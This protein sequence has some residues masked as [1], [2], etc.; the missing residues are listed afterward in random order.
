M[1]SSL[2]LANAA[3]RDN[4]GYGAPYRPVK[5]D[6]RGVFADID[7]RLNAVE[8]G[9]V[10]GAKIYRPENYGAVFDGSV[11]TASGVLGVTTL[12]GLAAYSVGGSTPYSWVNPASFAEATP[13]GQLFNLPLAAAA[14]DSDTTVAFGCNQ[15]VQT[16]VSSG[17]IIQMNEI[18]GIFQGQIVGNSAS[19]PANTFVEFV[20]PRTGHVW[21][22]KAITGTISSSTTLTFLHPDITRVIAGMHVIGPKFNGATTVTS[23]NTSSGV[24]GLSIGCLAM[25][26]RSK[27]SNPT[28]YP[29][30]YQVTFWAPWTDAQASAMSMDQL[31]INAAIQAAKTAGGGRV[32]LPP[33]KGMIDW[34][35]VIPVSGAA[36]E[37]EDDSAFGAAS[38]IDIVGQGRGITRLIP[39]RDF[40]HGV[41]VVAAAGDFTANYING[42]G[43]YV[44]AY[45]Y[46][47]SRGLLQ[48][49]SVQNEFYGF[50]YGGRPIFPGTTIPTRMDG[51]HQGPR[52][53]LKRIGAHGFN[54][55]L[56]IAT[57]HTVIDECTFWGNFNGARFEAGDGSNVVLRSDYTFRDSFFAANAW[58][59]ISIAPGASLGSA[60]FDFIYLSNPYGIF[61]E[62]GDSGV[63][64]EVALFSIKFTNINAEWCGNGIIKDG[65]RLN[66][67]APSR[68]IQNIEF[69]VFLATGATTS[70]VVQDVSGW[71]AYIDVNNI[72]G[73]RFSNATF[74]SFPCI[75]GKPF[76]L[77]DG[78]GTTGASSAV[79]IVL[80]GPGMDAI[81][82]DY[83]TNATELISSRIGSATGAFTFTD[84]WMNVALE[85][86]G[87]WEARLYM[88]G[89]GVGA[90][91]IGDVLESSPS[92]SNAALSVRKAGNSAGAHPVVGMN[93]Q[94]WIGTAD[95]HYTV[96]GTLGARLPC[97]VD[98]AKS[99][100]TAV[101]VDTG[102]P[103]RGVNAGAL[104]DAN[105]IGQVSNANGGSSSLV[106]VKSLIRGW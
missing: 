25:F 76:I 22:N 77:C 18:A 44:A 64:T 84:G 101:K 8:A 96:V 43:V 100:G 79:G 85:C 21:L 60:D 59:G 52:R 106:Y 87:A 68:S 46:R 34:P 35:I 55:G 70:P 57:D 56:R 13:F 48:D 83:G 39:T 42:R 92:L 90:L 2:T 6:I 86:P 38:I 45:P 36:S 30:P 73:L 14:S 75:S 11:H 81:V 61:L 102:T 47:F 80:S 98:A 58:S 99:V 41:P 51:I 72:Y 33:N 27:M 54:N 17:F 50:S 19:I 31:G 12:A 97:K 82:R 69:D 63:S 88:V 67:G 29:E 65:T 66:G 91:A 24:V 23:V 4:D 49:F 7:T 28:H 78:V 104:T 15:T 103:G 10:A 95:G 94:L 3:F 5:P 1:G 37:N 53:N 89:S 32:V 9:T 71:A 74:E 26:V 16:T 105:L 93:L 62:P 40:G 20:N